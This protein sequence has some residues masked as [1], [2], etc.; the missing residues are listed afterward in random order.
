MQFELSK[1]LESALEEDDELDKIKQI[2]KVF[3][4]INDTIPHPER[5]VEIA[6]DTFL[7]K[8]LILCRPYH[9][10]SVSFGYEVDFIMELLEDSLSDSKLYLVNYMKSLCEVVALGTATTEKVALGSSNV[11]PLLLYSPDRARIRDL[12][13][14]EFKNEVNLTVKRINQ[15]ISSNLSGVKALSLQKV[16]KIVSLIQKVA[17][18]KREQP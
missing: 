10:K 11:D 16:E 9:Q 8:N 7:M 1:L 15:A 4:V 2:N 17:L 3:K 12:S 6:K 18:S 5:L 14:E 13:L